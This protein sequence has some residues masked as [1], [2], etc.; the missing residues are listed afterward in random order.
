MATV[1][2]VFTNGQPMYPSTENWILRS[3]RLG[4]WKFPT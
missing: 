1:Q 3:G 4:I 2:Q